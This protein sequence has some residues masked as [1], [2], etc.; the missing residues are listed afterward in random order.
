MQKIMSTVAMA[1]L[2]F[3][4]LAES[5]FVKIA[6]NE[7][8]LEYGKSDQVPYT[9]YVYTPTHVLTY[10]DGSPISFLNIRKIDYTES[11]VTFI[12]DIKTRKCC[13]D[14]LD[15]K[16]NSNKC[17]IIGVNGHVIVGNGNISYNFE[18]YE[19]AGEANSFTDST[20]RLIYVDHTGLYIVSEKEN[21][22]KDISKNYVQNKSF[23]FKGEVIKVSAIDG[24]RE[25]SGF[26]ENRKEI[27]A[28]NCQSNAGV[29]FEVKLTPFM[30]Q[31]EE[32]TGVKLVTPPPSEEVA[33]KRMAEIL[34]VPEELLVFERGQVKLTGRTIQFISGSGF[35]RCT[36]STSNL[37]NR[38]EGVIPFVSGSGFSQVKVDQKVFKRVQ[39]YKFDTSPEAQQRRKEIALKPWDE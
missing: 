31:I 17:R 9:D 6:D 11:N 30:K 23:D 21:P 3:S 29:S 10:P 39:N 37:A 24:K 8:V 22:I 19:V 18:V 7:Y 33:L 1:C 2:S 25:M 27:F 4:C 34:D 20:P 38:L 13:I 28:F 12:K 5:Y 35:S 32:I 14:I 16:E 36:S 26:D 15:D